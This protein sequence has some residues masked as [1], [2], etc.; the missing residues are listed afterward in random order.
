MLLA[1]IAG[2]ASVDAGVATKEFV[3]HWFTYDKSEGD[4]SDNSATKDKIKQDIGGGG[5]SSHDPDDDD[6][7][8]V[9]EGKT[10][11]QME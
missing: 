4:K 3:K 8:S 5:T 11:N 7:P 2:N 1:K 10:L 6:R 9:K